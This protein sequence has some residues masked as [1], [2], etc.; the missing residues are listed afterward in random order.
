MYAQRYTEMPVELAT[1]PL[2]VVI[3]DVNEELN[4]SEEGGG[5]WGKKENDAPEFKGKGKGDGNKSDGRDW[6]AKPTPA[7]EGERRG[8]AARGSGLLS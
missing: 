1:S 8:S 5:Q 3:N 2:E 4:A 6:H 7:G